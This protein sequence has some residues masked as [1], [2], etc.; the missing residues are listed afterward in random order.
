MRRPACRAPRSTRSSALATTSGAI[1]RPTI[2]PSATRPAS[3]SDR[4]PCADMITGTRR[5]PAQGSSI[6]EPRYV[7]RPCASSSRSASV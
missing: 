3:S 6:D 4:S 5:G 1:P 2:T 7:V